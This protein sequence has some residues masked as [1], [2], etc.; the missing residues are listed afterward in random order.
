MRAPTVSHLNNYEMFCTR[1]YQLKKPENKTMESGTLI[2]NLTEI[3][4][5][6]EEDS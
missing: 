3:T 4:K 5:A 1:D 6:F 2:I